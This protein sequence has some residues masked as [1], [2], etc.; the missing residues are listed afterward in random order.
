MDA[1]A[2]GGRPGSDDARRPPSKVTLL[3]CLQVSSGQETTE[4]LVRL[5][6]LKIE[7]IVSLDSA[8]PPGFWYEQEDYEWVLVLSGCGDVELEDGKM[9]RLGPGE[10]LNIP[11]GCRHRVARTDPD[12]ATVWLAV[13][14]QVD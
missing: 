9:V 2:S 7:R 1:V 3:E 5:P 4:V 11:P 12:V 10:A 13:R 14:A 8:S 6:G